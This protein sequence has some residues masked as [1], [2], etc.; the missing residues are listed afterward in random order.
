MA[1]CTVLS[2]PFGKFG[3]S[4][5]HGL[6]A[7]TVEA[8]L[9]RTQGTNGQAAT[10]VNDVAAALDDDMALTA[11]GRVVGSFVKYQSLSIRSAVI[12]KRLVNK[13]G[14]VVIKDS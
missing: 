9:R 5:I 10:L 12:G 1:G 6:G 4:L 14:K 13:N 3:M 7:M 2:R 8:R 11:T